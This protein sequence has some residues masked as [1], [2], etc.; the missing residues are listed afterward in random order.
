MFPYFCVSMLFK[1]LIKIKIQFE[2]RLHYMDIIAYT[3]YEMVKSC[4]IRAGTTRT[5][6]AFTRKC[7]VCTTQC[8][9]DPARFIQQMQPGKMRVQHCHVV[10]CNIRTPSYLNIYLYKRLVI[11]LNCFRHS[12]VDWGRFK[13]KF[14]SSLQ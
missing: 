14:F 10:H 6:H 8:S 4:M 7:P 12:F 9:V 3:L 1:S 13:S 5:V 11:K 2:S